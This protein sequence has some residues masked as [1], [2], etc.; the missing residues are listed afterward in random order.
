MSISNQTYNQIMRDYNHT[1]AACGCRSRHNLD[2]DHVNPRSNGGS[3]DADNLQV[4][5][6]GCNS[7][8]KGETV[9][10]P[11]LPPMTGRK[12]TDRQQELAARRFQ[13]MVNAV[14]KAG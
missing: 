5:C 1:C 6:H 8:I 13:L 11:K 2:I 12:L 7:R 3:D 9:G 4:L 14:R 10:L